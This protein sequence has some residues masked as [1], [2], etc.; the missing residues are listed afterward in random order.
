[1]SRDRNG[2]GRPD[3]VLSVAGDDSGGT[4]DFVYTF[5]SGTSMAAPHVAGVT[6]LMKAINPA[7]TPTQFDNLLASGHLT[8]DLGTAGRD[9]E[10]GYGL[11]GARAAVV[12]AQTTPAP[13]PAKLAATPNGLNFGTQGTNATLS[14]VNSGDGSLSVTSASDNASWLIVGAASDA[15]TGL[16]TRTVTVNRAGLTVGTY[17]A[18][19]TLVSTANTVIIPVIMQ[20]STSNA[21]ANAGFHYV[22]LIDPITGETAYDTRLGANNGVYQFSIPGVV[23]G[24]Y[25]V[26]AGSDFN[27]DLFICDAGEACGAY[28]V[29]NS[30]SPLRVSG[31]VTGVDFGTGFNTVIRAQSAGAPGGAGSRGFARFSGKRAGR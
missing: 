2:D 21:V 1:M 26:L 16:G 30:F 7:L 25:I 4:L 5:N 14:L 24:S 6:A 3:G 22:L 19:I 31:S 9:N 18:T 20:V 11:V 17:T 15:A 23:A 27:N 28:P 29:L 8:Q 13:A 12:A 10:F